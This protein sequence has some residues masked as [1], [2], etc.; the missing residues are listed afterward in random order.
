[1]W[2]VLFLLVCIRYMSWIARN[3]LVR[4]Y[5]KIISC[6][7]LS[8]QSFKYMILVRFWKSPVYRF[9]AVHVGEPTSYQLINRSP[10]WM[11]WPDSCY[12]SEIRMQSTSVPIAIQIALRAIAWLGT[13]KWSMCHSL[14]TISCPSGSATCCC[15]RRGGVI[16]SASLESKRKNSLA[17]WSQ[18]PANT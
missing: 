5:L 10:T 8:H 13:W 11:K 17:E 6:R 3:R 14:L 7:C 2:S 9:I 1:M 18:Q 16:R 15:C 12:S 4:F